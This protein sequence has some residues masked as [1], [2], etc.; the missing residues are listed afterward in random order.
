MGA[1][2]P[3][4][5]LDLGWTYLLTGLEVSSSELVSWM[6]GHLATSQLSC[7][8]PITQPGDKQSGLALESK[9]FVTWVCLF[10]MVLLKVFFL[11]TELQKSQALSI[12]GPNYSSRGSVSY[13]TSKIEGRVRQECRSV[14]S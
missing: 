10:F 4:E 6:S 3:R 11:V 5:V 13:L 9:N 14:H 12:P 1:R 8:D 7:F 2:T